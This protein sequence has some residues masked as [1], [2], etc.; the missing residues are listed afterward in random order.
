MNFARHNREQLTVARL[1]RAA[2]LAAQIVSLFGDDYW[3]IFD[4]LDKELAGRASRQARLE[5]FVSSKT[6]SQADSN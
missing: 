1:E 6:E 4:R 3:P 2:T 5:K